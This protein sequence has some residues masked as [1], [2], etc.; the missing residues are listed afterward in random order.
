MDQ[1]FQLPNINGWLV[2]DKPSGI[3]S[4]NIVNLVKKKIPSTKVGHG[5]LWIPM[6]LA[7]CQLQLV[8][9]QKQYVLLKIY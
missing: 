7:Y 5:E 4:T 9:Q 6:Q 1:N 2:I 8:K 3:G